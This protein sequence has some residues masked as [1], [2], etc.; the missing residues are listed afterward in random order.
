MR[1]GRRQK[2]C[3]EKHPKA[4]DTGKPTVPKTQRKNYDCRTRETQ[5]DAE[6]H[7]GLRV[8]AN[9]QELRDQQDDGEHR[10]NQQVAKARAGSFV[11]SCRGSRG[12]THLTS[13]TSLSYP[14]T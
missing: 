12:R 10:A 9:V 7:P 3:R 6:G 8:A 5:E 14:L 2:N 1:F 13:L 11:L 4:D